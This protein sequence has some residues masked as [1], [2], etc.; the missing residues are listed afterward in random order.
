MVEPHSFLKKMFITV[1]IHTFK[2][3]FEISIFEKVE[4]N[5]WIFFKKKF[6]LEIFEIF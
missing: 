2:D 1:F 5:F 4:K 3:I 6:L